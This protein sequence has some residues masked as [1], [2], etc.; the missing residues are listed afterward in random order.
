MNNNIEYKLDLDAFLRL[1]ENLDNR[2]ASVYDEDNMLLT[3]KY[4][5]EQRWINEFVKIHNKD[6]VRIR[7]YEM[8]EALNRLVEME[9]EVNKVDFIN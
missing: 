7:S 8:D 1:Y 4:E 3:L 5:D 2:Y 6:L 9:N